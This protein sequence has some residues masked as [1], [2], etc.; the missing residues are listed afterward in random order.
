MS[1]TPLAEPCFPQ[2]AKSATKLAPHQSWRGKEEVVGPRSSSP[3]SCDMPDA[4]MV[5]QTAMGMEQ[6]CEDPTAR[7]SKRFPQCGK[8]AVPVFVPTCF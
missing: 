6:F 5:L 7:N 2:F 4:N 8:G 3:A 1:L